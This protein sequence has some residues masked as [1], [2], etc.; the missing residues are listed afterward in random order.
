ML[1]TLAHLGALWEEPAILAEA[2]ELVTLLPD[3]V[4]QDKYFDVGLG[5]AG[6]IAGLLCLDRV[7]PSPQL[8]AVAIKCGDHLLARARP[9]PQGVGWDWPFP[10]R[11]PLTGY[12]H[13]A[14]GIALAL[15][16]LADFSGEERFR[17]AARR[18]IDYE[19][20]LFSA[21][22]GNWPDLRLFGTAPEQAAGT[23][24]RYSVAWCYGAAGI[25][26]ARLGCRRHLDDARLQPELDTALRTTRA[27]GFGFSHILCHGDLGN[28]ELLLQAG[29]SCPASPWR[30]EADRLAAGILTSID[31]DGWRCANP[32]RLES[33]G[34]MTGL[35][36]IGYQ[37]L[38]LAEPEKVPS[39][40]TLAPTPLTH[41]C[42]AAPPAR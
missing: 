2:Q 3:L 18:A 19:R 21:E 39:V 33:P 40:L 23:P 17:A 27:K 20:S 6:C 28:L 5:A 36:G 34:L 7:A 10:S 38:R 42:A 22:A 14:A 37:L 24:H 8:R 1:Y 15:L 26:L 13:G 35:S 4:E 29:R 25:G 16:E 11:G 31:R 41:R 12:A 32:M 9:M 30:V